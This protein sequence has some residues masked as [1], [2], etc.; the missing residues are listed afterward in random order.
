MLTLVMSSRF[1]KDYKRLKRSGRYPMQKLL[2][3]L[4][5]LCAEQALPPQYR[6]HALTGNFR[7]FR[8]CHISP[9]WLL[10][11]TFFKSSLQKVI[12]CPDLLRSTFAAEKLLLLCRI[13]PRPVIP[14]M[15]VPIKSP[16]HFLKKPISYY[17][18]F[19]ISGRK[20][21]PLCYLLVRK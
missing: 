1:K 3:V 9:D 17:S 4:D 19:T 11:Y 12:F 8:E 7:D 16:V 21:P 10:I 2:D 5:L 20:P 14:E 15:V 6:D 13:L 18:Y